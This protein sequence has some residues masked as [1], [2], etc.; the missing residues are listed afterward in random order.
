[1]ILNPYRYAAAATT[2][3]PAPLHWLDLDTTS[4]TDDGT[5][6]A[7]ALAEGGT[8]TISSGAGPNGQDVCNLDRGDYLRQA[9]KAWDGA[10]NDQFSVSYWFTWDTMA[11]SANY[12]VNWRGANATAGQLFYSA[13]INGTY[14]VNATAVFDN[15]NPNNLVQYYDQIADNDI[16]QTDWHHICA[17]YDGTAATPI[18]RFYVDGVLKGTDSNA[19]MSTFETAGM[20]FAIG[21]LASGPTNASLQHDGLIGMVGIWDEDIGEDGV[22]HLYNSG[23]GRQFGDLNIF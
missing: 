15:E 17:R 20:P 2:S 3:V 16:S 9:S 13:L 7:I 18:I 14:E 5:G 8:P 12:L 1:M 21:A 11:T 23:N 4:W 22:A 6:T 19:L 10:N